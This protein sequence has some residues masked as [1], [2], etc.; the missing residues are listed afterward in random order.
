[1]QKWDIKKETVVVKHGLPEKNKNVES[2][3]EMCAKTGMIQQ[4]EIH[5]STISPSAEGDPVCK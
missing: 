5:G 1:M 2:L 3:I 4:L